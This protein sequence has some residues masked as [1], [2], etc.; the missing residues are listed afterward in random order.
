M[1]HLRLYLESTA[2]QGWREVD[3]YGMESVMEDKAIGEFSHGELAAVVRAIHSATQAPNSQKGDL[4]Y[5]GAE[6]I[7]YRHSKSLN[8]NLFDRRG[9]ELGHAY[10]WSNLPPDVTI[11]SLL[12]GRDDNNLYYANNIYIK[13]QSR[14]KI[15]IFR[16]EDDW[17]YV[18]YKTDSSGLSTYYICDQ[19][20]GLL[21]LIKHLCQHHNN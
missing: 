14:L 9:L 8:I 4:T 12:K 19:L 10:V 21:G 17:F 13:K 15:D 7:E 20:P 3:E 2:N 5:W 6:I 16:C 11:A 1:R 18:R